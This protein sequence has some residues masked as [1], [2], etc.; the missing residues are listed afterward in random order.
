MEQKTQ[1]NAEPG[2]QE[3]VITRQFDLPLELLFRAF[4][5]PEL[6]EEWMG[7]EVLKLESKK[8]GSYELETN[9]RGKWYSG[10]MGRSMSLSRTG[11]SSGHSKWRTHLLAFSSKSMNLKRSPTTPAGSICTSY[12]N[13]FQ[14]ETRYCNLDWCRA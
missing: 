7:T 11:R 12:L 6:V 14:K 8:H 13:L 9:H 5:E 2:K 4:V 3:Y 10:P 1:V